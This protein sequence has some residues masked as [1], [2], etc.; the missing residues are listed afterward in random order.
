MYIKQS[1]KT[2]RKTGTSYFAYHLVESVRTDKGP[3]Q[4]VL[5]YMGSTIDIA[6]QEHKALA[7]RIEAIITGQPSLFPSTPAVER[8]AQMY[9]SQVINRLSDNI[10]DKNNSNSD[11]AEDLFVTINA[12]SL[13]YSDPRSVGT[14]HVLLEMA[15]QLDLPKKL[16]EL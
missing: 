9:A 15:K 16:H 3:R 4:R 5:L 8:L 1:F 7:E 14:E 10:E 13:E 2:D 12:N 6:I 11:D